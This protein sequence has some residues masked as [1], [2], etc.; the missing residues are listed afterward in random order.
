MR[1]S[2]HTRGCNAPPLQEY[3]HRSVFSPGSMATAI[4]ALFKR[5][6]G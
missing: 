5:C 4:K 1:S 2:I 6:A 3:T